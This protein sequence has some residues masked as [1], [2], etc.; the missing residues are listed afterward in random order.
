[1]VQPYPSL[2]FVSLLTLS[3]SRILHHSGNLHLSWAGPLWALVRLPWVTQGSSCLQQVS[4][5]WPRSKRPVLL[6]PLPPLTLTTTGRCCS[7]WPL[8]L[9]P[10]PWMEASGEALAV[11]W[12]RRSDPAW[13]AMYHAAVGQSTCQWTK[14][15]QKH[16]F[17][18]RHGGTHLKAQQSGCW[19]KKISANSPNL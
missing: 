17:W 6:T 2:L 10:A 15:F 1:M 11:A 5:T 14:T 19:G 8:I 18:A 9:I 3:P 13:H 4:V 7:H 16:S 12:G